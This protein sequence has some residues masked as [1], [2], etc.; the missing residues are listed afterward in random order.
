VNE[1][2]SNSL[3]G[4]LD[5]ATYPAALLIASPFLLREIGV[6]RYGIWMLAS[7]IVMS[8]GVIASG[9]GDA[10]LRMVAEK[11]GKSDHAGA[12]RTVENALG[13]HI[14]LG[15]AVAIVAWMLCPWIAARSAGELYEECLWSL[16]IACVLILIRA[17]ETVW[18]STLRGASL[19]GQAFYVSGICRLMSL[20][21][22]VLLPLFIKSVAGIMGAWVL[23]CGCGLLAQSRQVKRALGTGSL[24]PR[25]ERGLLAPLLAFGMFTWLQ[26]VAGL[27]FTQVDR[28]MVGL[29]FGAAQVT[30]Y[31][32]CAQLV[33]PIYGIAAAGLHFLFP[34]AASRNAKKD[35]DAGLLLGFAA[36]AVFVTTGVALLLLCGQAILGLI[37]GRLMAASAGDLLLLLACA[38]GLS[39][40]SVT[41]CY[42]MLALGRAKEVALF[43]VAGGVLG[44]LVVMPLSRLY[45]VAGL[46]YA[47]MLYG[48]M[49]LMVYIPL[50]L[51]FSRRARLARRT[52]PS[53]EDS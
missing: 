3:Y 51:H 49:V 43:S 23:I 36:N 39:A 33:Q 26:S 48:A 22:A 20:M 42:G 16:R 46:A 17:V 52:E 1:H 11:R 7:A 10:N 12:V 18:A 35:A 40:M 13:L 28:V 41:G 45:G 34:Y 21:A 2:L 31:A 19:Y 24:K 9:L 14:V 44:M 25:L 4:V 27:V 53:W 15:A 50:S 32:I 47:R 37:G 30:A 6:E 29:L 38:S 8:G 5:Y